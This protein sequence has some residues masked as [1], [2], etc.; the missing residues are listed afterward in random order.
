[1]EKARV[2][3]LWLF[4]L[5]PAPGVSVN[6]FKALLPPPSQTVQDSD[7]LVKQAVVNSS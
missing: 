7:Q 4:A 2:P 1:M 5:S 3:F 6:W